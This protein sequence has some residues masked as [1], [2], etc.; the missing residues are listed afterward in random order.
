M[1]AKADVLLYVQHLLGIGHLKRA[2]LIAR[3]AARQG[4]KVV[5]ASGGM[6]TADTDFSECAAWTR[7]SVSWSMTA[8]GG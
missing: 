5:V 2:A 3:A 4:L 7:P 1:Q 6:P 8:A